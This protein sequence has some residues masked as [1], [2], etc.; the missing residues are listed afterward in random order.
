MTNQSTI[1]MVILV[2][3]RFSESFV[4]SFYY[5]SHRCIWK[6]LQWNLLNF[7]REC[8]TCYHNVIMS[9]IPLLI[10][11]T[12]VKSFQRFVLSIN[13]L[14]FVTAR[15]LPTVLHKIHGNNQRTIKYLKV[16]RNL[17]SMMP[18]QICEHL[19]V[20]WIYI[21]HNCLTLL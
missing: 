9:P 20:N 4:R 2:I 10:A 5:N 7:F 1:I 8:L 13:I 15:L 14:W 12:S 11:R 17:V 3:L 21:F 16:N 19:M 6:K 18:A